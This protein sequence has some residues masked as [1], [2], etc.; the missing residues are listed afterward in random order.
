MIEYWIEDASGSIVKRKINTTNTNKKSFTPKN[1]DSDITIKAR[2]AYLACPGINFGKNTA[3]KTIYFGKTTKKANQS[4]D[5]KTLTL[6]F[7]VE[8]DTT[9]LQNLASQLKNSNQNT[10]TP[11]ITQKTQQKSQ[12]DNKTRKYIPYFLITLTTMLSIV[13][14]WRR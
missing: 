14:I 13:L 4:L 6:I 3:E 11:R 7:E 2:I 9:K 1:I 5:N 8:P 12:S 10:L